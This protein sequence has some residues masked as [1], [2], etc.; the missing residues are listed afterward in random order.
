MSARPFARLSCHVCVVVFAF[1]WC[2]ELRAARG[3]SF[4][5]LPLTDREHPGFVARRDA[6]FG[7]FIGVNRYSDRVVLNRDTSGRD[8]RAAYTTFVHELDF[9]PTDQAILLTNDGEDGRAPT[10]AAILRAIN[11]AASFARPEGVVV[12]YV[13]TTVV[14]GYLFAED[15]DYDDLAGTAVPLA[16]VRDYLADAAAPLRLVVLEP[17]GRRGL[18]LNG[19]IRPAPLPEDVTRV[20]TEASPVGVIMA[21]EPGEYASEQNGSGLGLFTAELLEA[22]RGQAALDADSPYITDL[23]ASAYARQQVLNATDGDQTVLYV[24]NAAVGRLPLAKRRLR[25]DGASRAE[26]IADDVQERFIEGRLTPAQLAG[27]MLALKQGGAAELELIERVAAGR[28]AGEEMLTRLASG[29]LDLPTPTPTPRRT[30]TPAPTPAPRREATPTPIAVVDRLN[31]DSEAPPVTPTPAPTATGATGEEVVAT[32]PPIV[33]PVRDTADVAYPDQ[34]RN[35]VIDEGGLAIAMVW[36]PPGSFEMGALRGKKD[37]KPVHEVR[38]GGFWMGQTE[39]TQRQYEAVMGANP[40]SVKGPDLPVQNVSWSDAFLFCVQVSARTG[41]E[42][43]LPTE[44]QWEYAGRAD[45]TSIW[46]FGD[47]PAR[48]GAHA[49]FASN[50]DAPQPVATR[51]PN[52][53]G[54]YDMT[55]NVAEWCFDWYGEDYYSRSARANPLGPEDG[56]RRVI[57]GGSWSDDA[58]AAR[59]GARASLVP[60]ATNATT[61]F[62]IARLGR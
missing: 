44:A 12:V 38:V 2:G 61:G 29:D 20:F 53:W 26:R 58:N 27:A 25:T 51:H 8:A 18:R 37:E 17:G 9:I 52:R 59:A 35:Y 15:S 47:D 11:D 60:V 62:R 43:Q 24:Q 50:T 23:T 19:R 42:Y 5:A 45:T 33:T 28:I 40:S 13:S 31:R 22:L 41:E 21:C 49:W 6:S 32:P 14:E 48:L 57:R 54:L 16:T 10:R 46:H 30:A 7:V 56:E 34:K 1:A 36:I 55:G 39:V 3:P 4:H